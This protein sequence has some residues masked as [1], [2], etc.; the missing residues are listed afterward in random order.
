MHL[1]T[2]D[3]QSVPTVTATE[4]RRVDELMVHTYQLTLLQMMENA[5]RNLA[6][7]AADWLAREHQAN[8]SPRITVLVGPGGNGGGGLVAA[9]HLSNRGYSLTLLCATTSDELTPVPA[10]QAATLKAMGYPLVTSSELPPS[11]LI[12]DCL[13]GYSL[14]GNP[15]E[16]LATLIQNANASD[17]PIIALD[18]P[19]GLDVT[20]GKPQQPCIKAAA[21]VTLALPKAGF[22]QPSAQ[23][24]LGDVYLADISVPPALYATYFTQP[25]STLLF[26][27]ARVISLHRADDA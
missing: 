7:F 23:A 12:L 24:C 9:R 13:L 11:D 6:D 18:T 25:T 16:P 15:R 1:E 8:D 3:G 27:G 22:L 26:G 14:K 5:G 20:T 21:T 19:S 4:M 10:H 17:T 2:P